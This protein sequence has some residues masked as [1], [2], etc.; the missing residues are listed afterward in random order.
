M[1]SSPHPAARFDVAALK[2]AVGEKVFARGVAYHRSGQVEVLALEPGRVL[3]RVEGQDHPQARR[4]EQ[5]RDLPG[6]RLLRTGGLSHMS[7]QRRH[8]RPFA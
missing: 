6:R 2:E 3:A 8:P 7:P 1:T 5:G 4:V